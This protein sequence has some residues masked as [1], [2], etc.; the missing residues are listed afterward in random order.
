MC[1]KFGFVVAK[2]LRLRGIACT[3]MFQIASKFGCKQ[4]LSGVRV[5]VLRQSELTSKTADQKSVYLYAHIDA[6]I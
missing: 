6:I 5:V 4:P 2:E 3:F 1:H